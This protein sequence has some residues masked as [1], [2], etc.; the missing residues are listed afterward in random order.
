[1]TKETPEQL[2]EIGQAYFGL[3]VRP[4]RDKY[5]ENWDEESFWKA[6]EQFKIKVRELGYEDPRQALTVYGGLSF[7]D[8]RDNLRKGPP[9][10]FRKGWKSEMLGESVDITF[11]LRQCSHLHGPEFTGNESIVVLD[12]WATWCGACIKAAPEISELA[13]EYV[14]QVSFVGIVNDGVHEDKEHDVQKVKECL[15]S[16]REGFKFANFIDDRNYIQ[17]N[18]FKKSGYSGVPCY[19]IIANRVVMY[20]GSGREG[21][22]E[23]LKAA[24]E[25]TIMV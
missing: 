13:E 23:A 17:E 3:L 21:F 14:G 15:E 22:K 5:E 25:G 8:L 20:V 4:F 12:L 10:C 7:G 9:K 11:A 2:R 6:V 24:V 18:I 19:I 1:M 16:N